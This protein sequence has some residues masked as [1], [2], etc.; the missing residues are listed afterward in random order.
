MIDEFSDSSPGHHDLQWPLSVTRHR[1][2]W[3]LGLTQNGCTCVL[4]TQCF[5][6][7][8]EPKSPKAQTP[9]PD[10]FSA[11]GELL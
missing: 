5:S 1:P 7:L 11:D 10:K 8:P 4:L 6:C 3:T 9:L 2:V